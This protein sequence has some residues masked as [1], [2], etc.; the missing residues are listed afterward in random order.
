MGFSTKFLFLITFF[1][2]HC[3]SPYYE[4]RKLPLQKDLIC[5]EKYK[6]KTLDLKGDLAFVVS[7]DPNDVKEWNGKSDFNCILHIK[8]PD[9]MGIISVIQKMSLRTKDTSCIDSIQFRQSEPMHTLEK[10]LPFSLHKKTSWSLPICGEMDPLKE[11][12]KEGT[13][14]AMNSFVA[15]NGYIEV[16]IHIGRKR[17]SDE[18]IDFQIVFTALQSCK[19]RSAN[20]MACSPD[21]C[22]NKHFFN[23][24]KY[25]N[26]PST[27]CIDEECLPV[28]SDG[29]ASEQVVNSMI[30]TAGVLSVMVSFI[31]FLGCYIACRSMEICWVFREGSQNRDR[32]TELSQVEP[33]A[34]PPDTPSSDKDLPPSY[35]TLFPET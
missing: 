3:C 9:K 23:D 28:D 8:S 15:N 29:K 18:K 11:P 14:Y 20:L 6:P 5:E 17:K 30:V 19:N 16:K 7:F 25:I 32:G 21:I 31:I 24:G 34:P 2:D 4:D 22:I 10:I 13:K 26:C 35:E 12:P 33:T 27:Q 1:G